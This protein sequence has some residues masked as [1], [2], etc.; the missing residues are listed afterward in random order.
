MFCFETHKLILSSLKAFIFLNLG[1]FLFRHSF[2]YF[3]D[4][5]LIANVTAKATKTSNPMGRNTPKRMSPTISL[6]NTCTPQ[7]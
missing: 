2:F 7:K 1:K 5:E 4:P 6:K 3:S